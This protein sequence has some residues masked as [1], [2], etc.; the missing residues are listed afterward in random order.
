MGTHPIF[1]SDFDCLTDRTQKMDRY[2]V[3]D[4]IGEGSFGR[5]YRGRRRYSGH[6]WAL[7]FISKNNRSK[8][9][10]NSL[11]RELNIMKDLK[12]P[13]I[14]CMHDSFE[15]KDEVVVVMEQAEGEL[16]QVLEDDQ[17][18]DEKM[19]QNIA[20]QLVSALYYL[21]SNRIL[22]RD[23]KPQN[24][25]IGKGGAI[26]LC[27]FGFARTMGQSTFVLT[28]I[29]GTPLYMAPELVQ[30][31]PYDHTADLW[32]LG[33][34]LYELFH[35]QPPFYTTSIFQLVSLIIQ[36]EIKW[37]P[38][39]S[40]ELTS[41]LKGILTK[42]PKRRLGWPHLLNHPFIRDHVKI[43]GTKSD[44]PLTDVLSKEQQRQ[45]EEQAKRISSGKRPG[46]KLLA[47]ARKQMEERKNKQ[48]KEVPEGT[49]SV[50]KTPIQTPTPDTPTPVKP[51]SI[52]RGNTKISEDFHNE[53]IDAERRQLNSRTK[54]TKSS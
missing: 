24:I 27:D 45:K 25:L 13:N 10:I 4:M 8:K 9:E 22:H 7:K 52:K 32:S 46:S 17:Q 50:K 48:M 41:F 19:I 31:K 18:L 3:L 39:M 35:G 1:E 38:N 37:P 15:T 12:H 49:E 29:K 5:V 11:K 36:D 40:P 23:M 6:T 53:I 28:S 54:N 2:K 34:I 26:K 14:I 33:C 20:A 16:F 30:E 21:H 42:D 44:Q 47:K 51:E 43:I